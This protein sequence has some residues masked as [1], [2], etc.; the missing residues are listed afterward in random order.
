MFHGRE[1]EIPLASVVLKVKRHRYNY[2]A[3]R[4]MAGWE[5]NGGGRCGRD[6]YTLTVFTA[7][8]LRQVLNATL[9]EPTRLVPSGS[10]PQLGPCPWKLR[11]A[12]K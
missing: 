6:Y 11:G 2:G 8:V 1:V 12:W 9:S 5:K 10:S 4:S 3:F 7:C